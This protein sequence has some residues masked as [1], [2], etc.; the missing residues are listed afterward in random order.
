MAHGTARSAPGQRTT[1]PLHAGYSPIAGYPGDAKVIASQDA[2][3][4]I[5]WSS[6]VIAGQNNPIP[7][8]YGRWTIGA[9][10][11]L[12]AKNPGYRSDGTSD[13]THAGNLVL[14]CVWCEGEIDAIEAWY[15]NGADSSMYLPAPRHYLGTQTQT[16]D[17]LLNRIINGYVDDLRGT[18]YS[19]FDVPPGLTSGFPQMTVRLRGLKVS[20][21][22]GGAKVWSDNPAYCIADFVENARYGMGRSIDWATVATVAAHADELIGSPPEKRHL[23]NLC[24]DE[25]QPVEQWLGIMRD[26]ADAWVMPEGSGYRLVLDSTGTVGATRNL[27]G[28]SKA[29]P[30][31][32]TTTAAHGYAAGAIV[33]ISGIV[34]GM[35]EANGAVGVVRA[36]DSTHFDLDGINSTAWTTFTNGGTVTQIGASSFSFTAANIA[37]LTSAKRGLMQSPTVVEVDYTDTSATPWRT[38]TAADLMF[39]PGVYDSPPTVPFRRTRVNKPGL[40]RK[41]EAT[42]YGIE[43]LNSAQLDDLSVSFQAFD[44]ALKLQAGDLIDVT[45]PS[46]I[47]AKIMRITAIEP[48]GPGRWN[49]AAAEHDDAKYST[50][51]V[52]GPSS[53]D[54]TLDSPL[55]PPTVTG[56]AL[57]E[58]NPQVATGD[59]ISQIQA[60]WTD[61]SPPAGSYPFVLLYRVDVFDGENLVETGTVQ[62]SADPLTPPVYVT[63][64]LPENRIYTVDVYTISTMSVPSA[65]A[66]ATITNAGKSLLPTDVAWIRASEIGGLVF[67]DWDTTLDPARDADTTGYWLKVGQTGSWDSSVT[68][69]RTTGSHYESRSLPVGLNRIF[70]KRLD[71]VRSPSHPYGQESVNAAWCDVVVTSDARAFIATDDTYA[72]PLLYKM[73]AVAEGWVTDFAQSWSSLFPS[74]MSFYGSPL[75]TY[76]SAG[77][78]VLLTEIGDAGL[79]IS[80]DWSATFNYSDLT[81]T[82]TPQLELTTGGDS[83][84]T[85]SSVSTASPAVFQTASNHGYALGDEV[86]VAS[87]AGAGAAAF[88]DR[89]YVNTIPANNQITLKR[90]DG[91]TLSGA[92][93]TYTGNSGNVARWTWTPYPSL[94]TK[95]TARYSRLRIST[96]GTMLV[97]NPIGTSRC[98][99]VSRPDGGFFTSSSAGPVWVRFTQPFNLLKSLVVTASGIDGYAGAWYKV[100]TSANRAVQESANA[101]R[102]VAASSQ[103]VT[104]PNT[105]ANHVNGTFTV[106]CWFKANPTVAAAVVLRMCTT[107]AGAQYA[108]GITL[109]TN[110][111]LR[112]VAVINSVTFNVDTPYTAS[113][114]VWHHAA[115]TL[116]S[117]TLTLYV[118]GILVGQTTTSGSWVA[119]TSPLGIGAQPPEAGVGVWQSFFDGVIQ[120]VRIW[121][122]ARTQAEIVALKDSPAVGNESGLVAC[123]HLDGTSGT[124]ATDSTSN[125]NTGTLTNGP[126]WRPLDGFDGYVLNGST[127]IDANVASWSATG[128]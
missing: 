41:S 109:R 9:A 45:H 44:V 71:S 54:T 22:S 73:S 57:R 16:P 82:A 37:R 111:T 127:K 106:E 87:C 91:T 17:P 20:T 25:P 49:I 12:V 67:L 79:A 18:A 68:L 52:S 31:R 33:K 1:A 123:Y 11:T 102:F 108:W 39:V 51:V 74:A 7:I 84:I 42:R 60:T 90:F 14:R 114:N 80:G 43:L 70:I 40:F 100:E 117:N 66:E 104:C 107:A 81:G 116:S 101:L 29:N 99:V 28:L 3:P 105:A 19:V 72:S 62:R 75:W 47:D 95:A 120:E 92:G 97:A 23:F 121:N 85:I 34:G 69:N 89:W 122:V 27:A 8:I 126:S 115:L 93:T 61:A 13:P 118:D 112:G 38:D 119:P 5:E 2:V 110:N 46:G 32:V 50:V 83:P 103:Y 65:P 128:V 94:S 59:Y 64:A 21:S 15:C 77:T 56:L 76:H 6:Q 55:N 113:D 48:A 86:L 125:A 96:T 24:L 10:I 124:S 53:G 88:N 4:T 58:L 26:Y 63:G 35:V 78:S 36:V 98:N 30:M